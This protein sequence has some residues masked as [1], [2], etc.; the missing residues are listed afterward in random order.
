MATK[1]VRSNS[2]AT[3]APDFTTWSAWATYFNALNLVT[4][5]SEVATAYNDSEFAVAGQVLLINNSSPD[6]T[7]FLTIQP[8]AGQSFSDNANVRTNALFYNSANGVGINDTATGGSSI[9]FRLL[10]GDFTKLIGLQIKSSDGAPTVELN[11]VSLTISNCIFVGGT[12]NCALSIDNT[13]W[14]LNNCLFVGLSTALDCVEM[15]GVLTTTFN[16]C[17]FITSAGHYV[18]NDGTA[19]YNN[20]AFFG[21]GGSGFNRHTPVSDTFTTCMTDITGTTGLTGGKTFSNQFVNTTND[22][23]AK[24]GADLANA[25]TNIGGITTDISGFTRNA[26]TPTMGAWEL[27]TSQK[28]REKVIAWPIIHT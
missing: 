1:I 28:R 21:G 9:C 27:G 22:F 4:T 17:T 13:G 6:A 5:G 2:G 26:S 20:C 7:H 25:G 8:A 11:A 3:P 19:T 12:G 16:F 14:T 23:R 18:Y 10:T 24:A 15:V